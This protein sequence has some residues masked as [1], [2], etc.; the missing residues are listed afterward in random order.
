MIYF[1][2]TFLFAWMNG[3]VFIYMIYLRRAGTKGILLMI[4]L[5]IRWY[6]EG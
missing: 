6:R 4:L 5:D 3:E 2:S 1:G